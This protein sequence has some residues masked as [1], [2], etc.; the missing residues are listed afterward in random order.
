M[1]HRLALVSLALLA[2]LPTFAS[3]PHLRLYL[4]RTSATVNCDGLPA[5]AQMLKPLGQP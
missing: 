3:P 1:L 2:S 5:Q 4:P